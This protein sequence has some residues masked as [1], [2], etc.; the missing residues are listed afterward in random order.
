LRAMKIGGQLAGDLQMIRF[1]RLL[2]R[3]A[4]QDFSGRLI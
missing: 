4:I 2:S 3:S 1:G